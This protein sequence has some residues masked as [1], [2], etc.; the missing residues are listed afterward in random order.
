MNA[1]C[2]APPEVNRNQEGN[3]SSQQIDRTLVRSPGMSE[4]RD[5]LCREADNILSRG[6]TRDWT[7]QDVVKHQGGDCQLC[8]HATHR[9]FDDAIYAPAC[10]H[11]ARLDVHSAH[12]VGKEHYTEDKPW[13]RTPDR[14]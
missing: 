14:L 7:S 8:Q 2:I 3:S 13:R 10:E 6:E 12:G 1:S 5:R 4:V 11:R 9:F